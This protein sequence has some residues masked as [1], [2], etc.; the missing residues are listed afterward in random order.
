M[1]SG[2]RGSVEGWLCAAGAVIAS[3]VGGL[4][5]CL[6]GWLARRV[7]MLEK[8]DRLDFS[9]LQLGRVAACPRRTLDTSAALKCSLEMGA[10]YTSR[11][12]GNC[13][14]QRESCTG[15]WP[16]VVVNYATRLLGKDITLPWTRLVSLEGWSRAPVCLCNSRGQDLYQYSR[17]TREVEFIQRAAQP[18]LCRVPSAGG[19]RIG[20]WFS[21]CPHWVRTMRRR[22]GVPA[23]G[24]SGMSAQNCRVG[25]VGHP[26]KT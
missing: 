10:A 9:A 22:D 24:T 26:E 15:L 4:F 12:P 5:L 2:V 20:L 11:T 23:R 18:C 21:W 8:V 25:G 19:K 1:A 7:G 16:Q 14:G 13:G 17:A 3:G 6:G